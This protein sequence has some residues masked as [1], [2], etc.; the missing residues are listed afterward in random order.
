MC[1]RGLFRS[2]HGRW[3]SIEQGARQC[4]GGSTLTSICM[5]ITR[6]SPGSIPKPYG[7]M[8]MATQG[9]FAYGFTFRIQTGGHIRMSIPVQR[10]C[11]ERRWVVAG[12]FG[13]GQTCDRD[14]TTKMEN[15][16][17]QR[18]PLLKHQTNKGF[19][20]YRICPLPQPCRRNSTRWIYGHQRGNRADVKFS[21]GATET[22]A[23][24]PRYSEKR[25]H[26]ESHRT[27]LKPET[28]YPRKR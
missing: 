7:S 9:M 23:A 17:S 16:I 18:Y 5:S 10:T 12:E 14:E 27:Q 15:L 4:S 25:R 3:R 28:Q 21:G 8:R 22:K 2:P 1:K 6:R 20:R 11:V 13:H 26:S 24:P 19:L